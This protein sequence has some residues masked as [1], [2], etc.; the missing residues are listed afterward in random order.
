MKDLVI[1]G[2]GKLLV[3]GFFDEVNGSAANGLVRLNV[4]GTPDATYAP[5]APVG[6]AVY[7]MALQP[8]GKLLVGGDFSSLGGS[9][10]PGLARLLATGV[11]DPGFV[12]VASPAQPVAQ[13]LALQPDGRVGL[14]GLNGTGFR[15]VSATGQPDP[16]FLPPAAS[17]PRTLLVQ[18]DGRIVVGGTTIVGSLTYPVVRLLP[19]GSFDTSFIRQSV[20][21]A[22]PLALAL[23]PDGRLLVGGNFTSYGAS[24]SAGVVRLRAN[25]LL[26]N[27]FFASLATSEVRSLVIQPN[28]RIYFGGLLD[29]GGP[30]AVSGTARLLDD[31]TTDTSYLPTLG[32]GY[33]ANKVAVQADGRLVAAGS[34]DNV[35]GLPIFGLTRLLD[36]N[37]LSIRPEAQPTAS[38][39]AWP[40]PA[41][42]NLHLQLEA[43]ARPRTVAVL[44]IVGQVV[45]QQLIGPTEQAE[46]TLGLQ[47]LPAG[48]YIL[49][50]EYAKS[51]A[52]RQ[53]SVE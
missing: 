49:R 8:D 14:A 40:V 5:G 24:A 22:S 15:R 21:G 35:S 37:V 9:A 2:D 29:T 31:G 10:R 46:L 51:I 36:Q 20:F 23:Y 30:A 32:P 13:T 48:H 25:D 4:D 12:P 1:Q 18:P 43:R 50:V 11:A 34:F 3:G 45:L 41:H 33:F 53:L 27:T 17:Y 28:Q 19:D 39:Q 42:D 7:A 16:T 44:T 47:N 38:F 52:T 26:D 6:S